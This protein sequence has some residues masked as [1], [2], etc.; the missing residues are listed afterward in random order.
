MNPRNTILPLL[1]VSLLLFTACERKPAVVVTVPTTPLPEPVP[2]TRTFETARLGAAIDQFERD[3]SA[4]R[5]ADV[6]KAMAELDG[7]IAE[8]EE[9]VAKR[10]GGERDEAALK[11]KNLQSYRTAEAARFATAQAKAPIVP[12]TTTVDPRSGAD[13]VDDAAKRAG[14]SVEKAVRDVGDALKDAVR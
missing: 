1:S 3:P 12:T 8:L 11:L 5:Q 13:K 6:K 2:K 10:T 4:S 9:L 7:E 14:H